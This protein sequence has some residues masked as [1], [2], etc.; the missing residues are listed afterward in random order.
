MQ[1][2]WYLSRYLYI[3]NLVLSKGYTPTSNFV[4]LVSPMFLLFSFLPQQLVLN[5]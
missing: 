2:H 5:S 3:N 1:L 4:T